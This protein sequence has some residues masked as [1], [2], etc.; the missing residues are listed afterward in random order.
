MTLYIVSYD[1]SYP[2]RDYESFSNAI[3]SYGNWWYQT[4]SVWLIASNNTSCAKIRDYLRQF[5]DSNDKLFVAKLSG[6]WAAIGFNDDEYN[7]IKSNN[8]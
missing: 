7:W 3:Q 5:I 1:L 8:R 4:G 2:R 6:E